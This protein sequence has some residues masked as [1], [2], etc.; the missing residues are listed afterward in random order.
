M[1][2]TKIRAEVLDLNAGRPD[3]SLTATNTVTYVGASG[4]NQYQFNG[5]YGVYGVVNGTYVLSSVSSSH[6]IAIIN[7]SK[8]SEISYT[9]AVNEGTGTGPDGNTYTFYSGDVTITVSGNF[10]TVSYYCLNHGYMGGKDNLIY[11]SSVGE[12]GLKMPSGTDVREGADT[13]GKIRNNTSDSSES[14]QSCMEFYNGT[15]W[16]TITNTPPPQL[17]YTIIAGG[18]AGGESWTTTNTFYPSGGGGA[19]G[20]LTTFGTTSGGG[21]AAE[22]TINLEANTFTVT[23]GAGAN[24]RQST[25]YGSKG[26][27]SILAYAATTITTEGGGGGNGPYWGNS[28][29]GS[30]GGGGG[31][32]YQAAGSGTACQGYGAG[33]MSSSWCGDWTGAGGGGAG[34]TNSQADGGPGISNSI[35]GAAVDYA[36]GGGGG[37]MANTTSCNGTGGIGGGG[38]GGYGTGT[39]SGVAGT[40]GTVNTGSGG[41]GSG[42]YS[43]GGAYA[44]GGGSGVV[45]LRLPTASYT[46]TT[47]GSPTVTTDG[48][49]TIMTFTGSGTY[50]Q[51]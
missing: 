32:V 45:I 36:G 42:N 19:G 39:Y 33:N 20:F 38:T 18:G 2:T 37:T 50:V 41:G 10:D 9:G 27:A 7:N 29:G 26:Q 24:R 30:G 22:S 3:Y 5:N 40:D 11:T 25:G 35:T 14:S 17:N 48:T 34:G 12:I 49:D 4:G 16:K 15:E 44:G 51:T 46:G 13:T 47:T 23:V 1:A 43:V 21:C 28:D 8:T 6:P 31:G